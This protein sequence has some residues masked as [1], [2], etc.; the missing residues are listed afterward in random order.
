MPKKNNSLL[1]KI[2][3]VGGGPASY[4][5]GTMHVR[6]EQAFGW[7]PLALQ[8]IEQCDLFAT[9]YDFTETDPAVYEE[10]MQLPEG[11]SLRS[12]LP[13]GAWKRLEFQVGKKLPGQRAEFLEQQH[14]M[15]VSTLLTVA[16]L[17]ETRAQTVDETLW[18]HAG[19]M[20]KTML[21]IES[22]A[23][24]VDLVRQI[25]MDT[26]LKGLI[27][28]LKNVEREKRKLK[29]MMRLYAEGDIQALYQSAKKGMQGKRKV[30]LTPRNVRMAERIAGIASEQSLFCAVGAAHL[31]GN[32]GLIRLLKKA[33]FKVKAV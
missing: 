6:D 32:K 21:G 10:L 17:V 19:A 11:M 29:R 4:L 20:G 7:I 28:L 14:P 26:H 27:H 15:A 12:M 5:F 18:S 9:E 24:Q 1:W 33:G 22:F 2:S 23:E 16:M 25:P 8:A 31:A 13:R 30:L 3:P